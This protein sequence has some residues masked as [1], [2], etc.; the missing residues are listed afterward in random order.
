MDPL[1]RGALDKDWLAAFHDEEVILVVHE[2]IITSDCWKRLR[3]Y[4]L[5]FTI[6]LG[7]STFVA[8]SLVL[9]IPKD[10][11]DAKNNPVLG[12]K[13]TGRALKRRQDQI[14]TSLA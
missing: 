3:K 11:S 2:V 14:Q 1:L 9:E 13:S 6:H 12:E 4:I 7:W 10:P 8:L 5:S